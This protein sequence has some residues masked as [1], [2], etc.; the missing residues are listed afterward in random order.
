MAC[1][2]ALRDVITCYG[3]PSAKEGYCVRG[4]GLQHS[5]CAARFP[6]GGCFRVG[7]SCPSYIWR[8][9]NPF[10]A[11]PLV[12][13]RV[14]GLPSLVDIS[15][16]FFFCSGGGGEGGSPRRQEGGGVR[17]LLKIPRGGVFQERRGGGR[18]PGGCLR[19]WGGGPIYFASGPK[20]PPS[21]AKT[22]ETWCGNCQLVIGDSNK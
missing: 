5:T 22:R 12:V 19:V 14:L 1:L 13:E 9:P 6:V 10:G 21:F 3:N 18:G 2:D 15:D 16:F 20:F 17:L 11:K 4:G 7:F 8:V